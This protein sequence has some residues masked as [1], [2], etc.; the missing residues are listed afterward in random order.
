VERATPVFL[1]G[2]VFNDRRTLLP[3]FVRQL[4]RRA[5]K[6]VIRAAR[7]PPVLGAVLLAL[8]DAG[9]TW[10]EPLLQQLETSWKQVTRA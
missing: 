5:P 10:N 6:A 3:A 8:R 7:F 9:V 1:T 4:R 2:G